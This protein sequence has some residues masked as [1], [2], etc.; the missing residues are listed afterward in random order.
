MHARENCIE[1]KELG[2]GEYQR[3]ERGGYQSHQLDGKTKHIS[4]SKK[5]QSLVTP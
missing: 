1:C 3:G 4:I 5:G 2:T